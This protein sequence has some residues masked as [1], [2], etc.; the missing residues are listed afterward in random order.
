VSIL[1]IDLVFFGLQDKSAYFKTRNERDYIVDNEAPKTKATDKYKSALK[2]SSSRNV[3]LSSSNSKRESMSESDATTLV[4]ELRLDEQSYG[5]SIEDE[6]I[7]DEEDEKKKKESQYT[8]S[9]YVEQDE[10]LADNQRYYGATYD[11][12]DDEEE[13]NNDATSGFKGDYETNVEDIESSSDSEVPET[14]KEEPTQ[15]A[16]HKTAVLDKVKASTAVSRAGSVRLLINQFQNIIE[17]SEAKK[18][19]PQVSSENSKFAEPLKQVDSMLAHPVAAF[20]DK[21]NLRGKSNVVFPV[22]TY[23]S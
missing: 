20:S 6:D 2:M 22:I 13:R 7:K 11:D 1:A 3:L 16:E 8:T 12:S 15:P 9:Y 14:V 21:I 17:D 23:D 19:A 18:Q 5:A 10:K 4:N